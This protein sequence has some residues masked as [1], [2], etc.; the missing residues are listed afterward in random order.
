[1]KKGKIINVIVLGIMLG[2]SAY[3][4]IGTV[5]PVLFHVWA[6][7]LLSLPAIHKY[8][9]EPYDRIWHDEMSRK[10]LL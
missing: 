7:F 9:G 5:M 3:N 6:F 2:I 8:I 4:S 10:G 1:M